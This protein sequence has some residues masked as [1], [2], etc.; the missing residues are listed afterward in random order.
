MSTAA[1]FVISPSGTRFIRAF[2]PTMPSPATAHSASTAP[3]PTES[4]SS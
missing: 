3:R 4:G 2:P 1:I